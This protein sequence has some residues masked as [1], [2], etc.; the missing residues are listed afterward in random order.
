MET[1]KL[2]SK[3]ERFTNDRYKYLEEIK[4]EL[5]DYL[6]EDGSRVL[7]TYV[8]MT[9]FLTYAFSYHC[10]IKG[11]EVQIKKKEWNARYDDARFDKGIYNIDRLAIR[12]GKVQLNKEEQAY[13]TGMKLA[14]MKTIPYGGVVLDG[15]ICELYTKS[16]EGKLK[17]NI[18]EEMNDA[19]TV[20][21][22]MMRA[23]KREFNSI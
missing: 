2:N 20:L 23:W 18:D 19:L 9:F 5:L 11:N 4:R 22:H 6:P 16:N 7:F 15:W 3:L 21:I 8:E 10:F 1:I 13:L 14:E 17:W 12:E